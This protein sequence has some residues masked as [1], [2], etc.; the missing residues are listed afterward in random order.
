[1]Q[2]KFALNGASVHYKYLH[3]LRT[4]LCSTD[5]TGHSVIKQFF[6]IRFMQ[7]RDT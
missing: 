3:E 2:Q 4:P 1:M 7:G 6:L 5:S